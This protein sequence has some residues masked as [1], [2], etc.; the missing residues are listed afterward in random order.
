LRE[1]LKRRGERFRKHGRARR[2]FIRDRMEIELRHADKIGER[3]IVIENSE[4]R[5][6]GTVAGQAI[7]AIFALTAAGVNFTDNAPTPEWSGFCNSHEFVAQDAAKSHV[8]ANELQVGFADAGQQDTNDA[9][10]RLGVG[11]SVIGLKIDSICA[12]NHGTHRSL[13]SL[14]PNSARFAAENPSDY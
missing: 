14:A 2:D 8:A 13:L 10:P 12:E 11:C 1:N 9:F 4:H 7:P 5:P 3:A 6:G